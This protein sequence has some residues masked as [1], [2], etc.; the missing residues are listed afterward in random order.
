MGLEALVVVDVAYWTFEGEAAIGELVINAD[1][2]TQ[3][4]EAFEA[5]FDQGFPFTSIRNIDEFAG[6]DD[7]SMAADNTS[8]YNCRLAVSD[9]DPSWSKHAYGRAID[10]NPVENP[11]VFNGETL[12]P[13]GAAYVDRTARPGMLV[14]GGAALAALED[15][16]FFWG[17]VWSSP[18]YQ[19][20]EFRP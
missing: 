12:P 15:A 20:I 2:E 13:E 14:A 16:G 19:H 6:S 8:G 17:G 11:Y 5:L 1:I 9:G 18:D 4:R 3:T 7:A 10:I